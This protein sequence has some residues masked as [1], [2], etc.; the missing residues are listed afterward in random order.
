MKKLAL[1][2]DRFDRDVLDRTTGV[3]VPA[4]RIRVA[5]QTWQE[6]F[7]AMQLAQAAASEGAKPEA[8]I[9]WE[10]SDERAALREVHP[11]VLGRLDGDVGSS[12]WPKEG[13]LRR[14]TEG[15]VSGTVE[16]VSGASGWFENRVI[17][18]T[19]NV[20]GR[21]TEAAADISGWF[22]KRVIGRVEEMFSSLTELAASVS[23]SVENVV[24]QKGVQGGV[25]II[26]HLLGRVL[27][28]TEEVLGHP[29]VIGLIF[30]I[31]IIALLVGAL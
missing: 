18:R 13:L 20:F 5:G 29:L 1:L 11:G 15:L 23:A 8:A 9:R 3:P 19:E 10:E 14:A 2:L 7:M 27:T 22:E 17:G 21:L 25:P 30:L 4:P 31:S 24:F 6:Q 16:R 26:G 28:R 12:S